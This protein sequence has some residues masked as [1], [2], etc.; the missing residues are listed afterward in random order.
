M[1]DG[2]GAG[3]GDGAGAT[4]SALLTPTL[5]PTYEMPKKLEIRST[6][7]ELFEV[8]LSCNRRLPVGARVEEVL[9][10]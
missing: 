2:G 4:Q 3:G 7:D 9:W 1:G 6:A 8:A 10:V 5:C